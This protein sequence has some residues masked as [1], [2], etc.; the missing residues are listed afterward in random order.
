MVSCLMFANNALALRNTETGKS[1]KIVQSTKL[2][3]MIL[4]NIVNAD[5]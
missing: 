1:R 4:M 5:N 2:I 3:W